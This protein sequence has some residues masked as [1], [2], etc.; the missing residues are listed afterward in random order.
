MGKEVFEKGQAAEIDP[1]FVMDNWIDEY[2]ARNYEVGEYEAPCQ[3]W[4]V[5]TNLI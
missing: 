2:T 4:S 5:L 1:E 3:I